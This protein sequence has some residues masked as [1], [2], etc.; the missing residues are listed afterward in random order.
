MEIILFC[1]HSAQLVLVWMG[2]WGLS[3]GCACHH[4]WTEWMECIMLLIGFLFCFLFSPLVVDV[5]KL[6][7]AYLVHLAAKVPFSLRARYCCCCQHRYRCWRKLRHCD[8]PDLCVLDP[9][10]RHTLIHTLDSWSVPSFGRTIVSINHQPKECE[11]RTRMR[12]RNR[13]RIF[14]DWLNKNIEIFSYQYCA[15]AVA[16]GR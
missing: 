15:R 1:C 12:R 16:R 9:M 6:N 4:L 8:C 11:N 7:L 10:C 13:E 14:I 5:I 2:E 3:V